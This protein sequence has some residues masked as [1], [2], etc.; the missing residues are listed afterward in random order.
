MQPAA[1]LTLEGFSRYR[2]AVANEIGVSK[3]KALRSRYIKNM[4]LVPMVARINTY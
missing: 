4:Y 1:L 3:L 2:F